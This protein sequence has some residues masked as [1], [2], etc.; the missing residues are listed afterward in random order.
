VLTVLCKTKRLASKL[1][2]QD[3]NDWL[4]CEQDGYADKA[5]VPDYRQ[6]RATIA[7]NSNGHIPT[8][9]GMLANGIKEMPELG[10]NPVIPMLDPISDVLSWIESLAK[11]EGLFLPIQRAWDVDQGLRRRINPLFRDQVS[12]LLRMNPSQI[13]SIPEQIKNKV[14]EWACDL[15]VAGM[16]GDGISFTEKEKTIA[17]SITFNISDSK[18][19]Q[20]N[21]MGA[22]HAGR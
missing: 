6:V 17:H 7:M 9:F 16:T 5:T 20:L 11:G 3:I 4:R 12:F 8:G 10:I 21:N 19:G 15:E 22:N 18:I 14:L 1:A 2:R 13:K